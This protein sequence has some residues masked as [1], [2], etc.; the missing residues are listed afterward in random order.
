M[1][2]PTMMMWEKTVLGRRH[3]TGKAPKVGRRAG[4]RRTLER[5]M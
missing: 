4:G 2:E 1:L 3:S 5:L